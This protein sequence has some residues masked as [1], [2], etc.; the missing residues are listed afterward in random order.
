MAVKQ[1]QQQFQ[2]RN[3]EK[4]KSPFPSAKEGKTER[5]R[6]RSEKIKTNHTARPS[7]ADYLPA[8]FSP[9]LAGFPFPRR[10][11]I[12][13]KER[14]RDESACISHAQEEGGAK[15][16]FALA[17]ARSMSRCTYLSL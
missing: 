15:T 4:G 16:R 6:R 8:S 10:T 2:L 14:E 7:A 13:R 12:C 1:Q 5:E 17:A 3:R 11:M 9:A